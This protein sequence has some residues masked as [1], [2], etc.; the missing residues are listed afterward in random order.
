MLA[1]TKETDAFSSNHFYL[2]SS[3]MAPSTPNK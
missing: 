1:A 2:N 3:E